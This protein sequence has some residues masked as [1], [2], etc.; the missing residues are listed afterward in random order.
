VEEKKRGQGRSFF[1]QWGSKSLRSATTGDALPWGGLAN[2]IFLTGRVEARKK[3]NLGG[4]LKG[5]GF[6]T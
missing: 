5:R 4:R 3:N 1:P 6:L 2:P